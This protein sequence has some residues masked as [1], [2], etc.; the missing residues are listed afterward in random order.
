MT[1]GTG[2]RLYLCVQPELFT[3]QISLREECFCGNG[4]F[5]VNLI[6]QF[7]KLHGAPF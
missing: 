1:C 5:R 7:K 4:Y 2:R 6:G 3:V